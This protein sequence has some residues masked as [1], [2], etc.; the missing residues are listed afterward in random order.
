[1]K[2]LLRTLLAAIGVLALVLVGAVVYVTTFFDPD[3]LKPRLIEVVREQSGL[4]LSLEG[5]LTWSFY[6]RLGVSVEKAEAWLPD[7]EVEEEASF[8]AFS[9]AEVSLSFAPL[10]RG[11]IAIDGLTLDGMRLNLER[12]EEGRGNWEVLLERLAQDREAAEGAL[13]P[14]S[15]GPSP[16]SADTGKLSVALNIASVQ[17][18]EGEIRFRDLQ[19]DREML[20]EGVGITG[21]N[22]NP[23][24]PFSLKATFR[25]ATH[26]A[27]DWRELERSPWLASDVSLES[28]VSLGLADGRYVLEGLMLNTTS[29]LAGVEGEQKANLQGSELVVDAED[30]RL[31]LDEGKLDASLLHPSLGEKTLPLSLAFNLDA[32]LAEQTAQ[33]RELELTGE[34]GLRLSG[35]LNLSRL[36]TDPAY[37]G[38]LSLAPLSLRPWLTR[39]EMMPTM[40]GD[41]ALADVALTSPLEGNR[42]RLELTGLTLVLDD[43]TF[44][45]RLAA[46]LDGRLLDF[47]LQG[48][49][50]D[51]D[52]YL[53][54][55]EPVSETASETADESTALRSLPGIGRARADEPRP[56][57]PAEWL[58]ELALDGQLS[59][60]ELRLMGLDFSDVSLALAGGDGRLRLVSF[61]SGFQ[62]GT[63]AASGEL[64]LRDE[65]LSWA[66]A[67][68]LSRVRID[69]LLEALG[70]EPAPLRGRLSGEGELT[71][72]G[73][74]WPELKRQLS[75]PFAARLE[76]GAILEVNVS[77]ELCTAVATLEGEESARDWPP[78]TR[79]DR[80]DATF[81]LR[82]GTV[83]SDD[84]LVTIP[85]IELGGEGQLDLVSERFGLRAAARFVDTADAACNVNPRLERVPFPV[86]CEGGLGDDSSDWCRFDREAFRGTVAELLRD[87][88][89]RRAGEEVEQRLEG[90]IEDLDE[91]LGGGSGEELRDAL[92]GLFD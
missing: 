79:F 1:M 75:G 55:A 14:A 10:L 68:Q 26:D 72:R 19:A 87:E 92:R 18:R 7:Q 60:G 17:L 9:R 35:N 62:E 28:R 65:P 15:A 11:E 36:L 90:A 42:E 40:A 44:T 77:R 38:Q 50:L 30:R 53:P 12:D 61:E 3:D 6:P 23:N 13:A 83:H 74:T 73:N 78:D 41:S 71:S 69:S 43:S 21:S 81:E 59:L 5:P 20:F 33:L 63:L 29:R 52:A 80:A 85:G 70:E 66:L 45:G 4:E 39:L 49:S 46:G 27:L 2:R 32:D 16:G 88:A 47:D 64:G 76:E 67:P 51:L 31:R 24:R 37:T 48:D 86:R 8:A 25:L 82:D 89:S 58:A 91:R 34:D 84:L 56:L 54:P 57:V 22:V